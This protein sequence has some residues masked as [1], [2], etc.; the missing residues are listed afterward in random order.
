MT[1]KPRNI[2]ASVR[3]R[4]LKLSRERREDFQ[5]MVVLGVGN[6]RM[7]DFYDV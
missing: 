1:G 4:L 6:S 3:E 5:A 7:K 2:A